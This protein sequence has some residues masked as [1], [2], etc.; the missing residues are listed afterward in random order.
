MAMKMPKTS[1]MMALLESAVRAILRFFNKI[2]AQ[3]KGVI[4][5]S[6]CLMKRKFMST[7]SG[8]E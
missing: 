5:D 8:K 1:E 2:W 4:G 6:V 7:V 3:W